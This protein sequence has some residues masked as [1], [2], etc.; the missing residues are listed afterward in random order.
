MAALGTEPINRLQENRDR[1]LFVFVQTSNNVIG[2][3]QRK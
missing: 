3:S 2:L 1:L